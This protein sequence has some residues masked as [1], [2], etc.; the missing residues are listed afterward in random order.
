MTT[1]ME[2][3]EW[4]NDYPLLK[5]VNSN[6]PFTVPDGYFDEL[7]QRVT[8][9]IWLDELKNKTPLSGY[10]VPENYFE[11]LNSNIQSRINIENA[12]AVSESSGFIV[13]ENYFEELNSNIQSRINI[14]NALNKENTGYTV[15]ENYFEGL[16]NQI[17][18]R[19][20]VEDALMET[21][22]AFTVP[23][24]YFNHLNKRILNKT[25]NQDI[26]KHKS[27]VIR[28]FSST[29][30]KYAT[31]ACFAV[32]IGTGVLLKQTFAP[33]AVH[34]RSFLHQQLSNVPV[35]DIQSYLQLSVDGN[36]TQHA[37]VD[38]DL[39]VNDTELNS[40]LQD[41]ANTQ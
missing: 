21:P 23:P 35:N 41:Y 30:F 1:D 19:I 34:K 27:A 37:V 36:D 31:A 39:P 20:L 33:S 9:G 5:Q 3:R 6:N 40:A 8:S 13:P 4:L 11:E 22:E 12:L 25:V 26:V 14:E 17:K 28:F 38:E 18:S 24:D 15:P 29:A 2:N 7:E 16:N 10:T 32:M